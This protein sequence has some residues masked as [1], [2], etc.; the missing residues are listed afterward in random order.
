[1]G[2]TRAVEWHSARP[3]AA[4]GI[5]QCENARVFVKRH[6]ERVRAVRDLAEEHDYIGYLR[7]QGEAVPQVLMTRDGATSVVHG[8]G[9]YEVHGLC[10][11]ADLYRDAPSWTP[12]RSMTEARELGRALARLHAAGAGFCAP[13]RQT[14]LV[15]A[16]DFLTREADLVGA[17]QSWVAQDGRLRDALVG[18]PWRE[19]FRRE[20]QPWHDALRPLLP[21]LAP[22]WVHGDFHASN[23]LWRN[24]EVAAVLDFGLCNRASAVYDLATA[25]E[26]NAISW[27]ELSD[28][29][30]D[31]G[32]GD[33]ACAILDGYGSVITLSNAQVQALRHL[34]PLVHVEFALSELSYFH[35][36]T[37]SVANAELAY[38]GFLLG[39]AAWFETWHG[40]R[41]LRR[42]Q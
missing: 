17:A 8:A 1:L 12:V 5:V 38:S 16:G 3:F 6:D 19:D 28:G 13:A 30:G 34:L 41:L 22:S 35:D 36:I 18:R 32:H 39:H 31:I 24:G 26:R 40:T 21:V 11:G 2:A 9:V 25:I 7:G 4:S 23:L 29:H 37:R 42:L 33:L 15:V 10:A 27:L 14:R 20:L